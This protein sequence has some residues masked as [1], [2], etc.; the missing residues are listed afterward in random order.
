MADSKQMIV[1]ATQE[2]TFWNRD[3]IV[4]AYISSFGKAILTPFVGPALGLVLSYLPGVII[5]GLMGKS[6]MENDKM[7]GKIVSEPTFFNKSIFTGLLVSSI[8]NTVAVT[9]AHFALGA[10]FL[11]Y[12]LPITGAALAVT[13]IGGI[14]GGVA[15]KDR[16]TKE[17]EEAKVYVAEHGNYTPGQEK[18]PQ[19]E[20]AWHR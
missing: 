9:G 17:Y 18:A 5:G 4:G 2:P 14:M 8:I 12:A 10:S 20:N 7:S 1:P 11:T 15:G 16:L 13:L 3:A 19:T 6:R